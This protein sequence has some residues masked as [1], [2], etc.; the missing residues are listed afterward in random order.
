VLVLV[1]LM[2]LML[3]VLVV[4]LL[5][6]LLLVLA[7]VPPSLAMDQIEIEVVWVLRTELILTSGHRISAVFRIQRP[8]LISVFQWRTFQNGYYIVKFLTSSWGTTTR[9]KKISISPR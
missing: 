7:H 3:G 6:R 4:L 1:L 9:A 2:L 5:V 8:K